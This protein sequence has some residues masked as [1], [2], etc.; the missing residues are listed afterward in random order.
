[1][2]SPETLSV[3]RGR[4]HHANDC[5]GV[6]G[7]L[8]LHE[9]G[10]A[11]QVS[12]RRQRSLQQREAVARGLMS[13]SIRLRSTCVRGSER[14]FVPLAVIAAMQQIITLSR[15]CRKAA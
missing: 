5:T 3:V 1:M 9:R 2:I 12:R 4:W 13:A 10:L 14:R 7:D 15:R 6:L 8:R 11:R